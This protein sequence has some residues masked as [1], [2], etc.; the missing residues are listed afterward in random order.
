[1]VDF[2]LSNK[3]EWWQAV[4]GTR[5]EGELKW[6]GLNKKVVFSTLCPAASLCFSEVSPLLQGGL[7]LHCHGDQRAVGWKPSYLEDTVEGWWRDSVSSSS[8]SSSSSFSL[9]SWFSPSPLPATSLL[10]TP[11]LLSHP[12]PPQCGSALL[13]KLLLLLFLLFLINFIKL[14]LCLMNVLRVLLLIIILKLLGSKAEV[15][16]LH[17]SFII[18]VF[19]IGVQVWAG[20]RDHSNN[21]HALSHEKRQTW[22]LPQ[23]KSPPGITEKGL[24]MSTMLTK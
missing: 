14:S 21:H 3:E 10:F 23:L 13:N 22:Y 4:G 24:S 9:S 1:M 15:W 12:P 16:E 18:T 17:R 2:V 20:S 7:L 11:P 6:D 5:G 8:T 19:I